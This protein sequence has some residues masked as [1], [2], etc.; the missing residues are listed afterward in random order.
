V[1]GIAFEHPAQRRWML[2]FLACLALLGVFAACLLALLSY[3]VGVWGNNIPVTWALDIIGYDW[4]IGIASGGMILAAGLLLG[5]EPARGGLARL[6][7]SVSL[8]AAAAA[9]LYPIIHLGRPWFFYWTLPYPN[10][11]LLWPQFRSPLSWDA[12]A[13]ISYLGIC[14]CLWFTGLLPDLAVLRDRASGWW[15]PRLYGL[16]ALGWRGSAGHWLRW[17]QATRMQAGFGVVLVVALQSGAAVMFAGTVEPGWHDT[18]LPVF[19][20]AGAI[21][22]GIAGVALITLLVRF[23]F[24]LPALITPRHVE[25]LSWLMLAAGLATTYCYIVEFFTTAY[26]GDRFERAVMA[27]RVAGIYGW[28]FWLIVAGALLPFHLLWVRRLRGSASLLAVIC[29]LTLVG[30]WMDRFMIIVVTLHHDFLPSSQH[31]YSTTVW[32]V[33]TFLGTIGLFG[34]L[35]LLFLRYLPMWSLVGARRG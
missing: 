11:L 3:G 22:S 7:V 4:W 34:A 33:G 35:L 20:L 9:G 27:S 13:I 2:A 14:L 15:R 26:G 8:F 19:F 16:A 25:L 1:T 10:L 17:V 21:Y 5:G 28:S 29:G 18:L 30:M 31:F 12:V 32:A 24:D 23:L 6:A